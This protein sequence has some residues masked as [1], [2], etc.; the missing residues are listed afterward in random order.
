MEELW[1]DE[2][3]LLA[4]KKLKDSRLREGYGVMLLAI[5][6]GE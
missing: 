6:R 2:N 4:G 3:S 1:H 5:R